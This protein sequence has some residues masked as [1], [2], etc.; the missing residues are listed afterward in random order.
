MPSYKLDLDL[1]CIPRDTPKTSLTNRFY[2]HVKAAECR[3]PDIAF[4]A[5]LLGLSHSLPDDLFVLVIGHFG[6]TFPEAPQH[7]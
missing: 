1:F 3:R 7:L 6:A 4:V 5:L 2:P